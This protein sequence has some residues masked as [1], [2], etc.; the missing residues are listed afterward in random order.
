MHSIQFRLFLALIAVALVSVL[1]VGISANRIASSR[2]GQFVSGGGMVARNLQIS[3]ASF[4]ERQESWAG[5]QDFVLSLAASYGGRILV[6][7]SRAVV[8]AD[9]ESQLLGERISARILESG[10][11]IF[12]GSNQVG[13]LLVSG[14]MMG[15]MG[16]GMGMRHF[17]ERDFISSV[18]RSLAVSALITVFLAVLVSFLLSRRLT[19]PI[20]EVMRGA[21]EMAAGNLGHRVEVASK[22]EIGDLAESFN[23]MAVSLENAETLRRNVIAD[24][25]HELRTPLT[26]I[27]G[28]L[29]AIRDGVISPSEEN[30]ASIH[31]ETVLL[32]R[33][34]DDLRDLSQ[35]EAGRLKLYRLA[36][37]IG[38]I[39]R[40]QI[41]AAEP[42]AAK[43]HIEIETLIPEALPIVVA[44]GDRM[45]Q[46]LRNL[47]NNSLTFTPEGGKIQVAVKEGPGLVEISVSDSGSG[48][49]AEDLPFVFER[50]YRA[51][52]SRARASGGAGLGLT[53]AKYLVE[54]HGGSIRAESEQGK[55]AKFTFSVP[56]TQ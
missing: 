49:A 41:A 25:A 54:A 37:D 22:D 55:G 46:V 21:H 10:L 44:D 42:V 52:K 35:A 7:D 1:I 56:L 51:D 28:Y 32:A 5:V 12:S 14:G 45:G 40:K 39:A 19:T 15:G 38:E 26:S 2:F 4:Y 18:N 17:M 30:V 3:L 34:V 47:L 16:M 20:R 23:R 8:A 50:F 9:S 53:I 13:T 43:K 29:E 36:S 33:L 48:I 11:P 6:V 31:E 24:I 27:Q